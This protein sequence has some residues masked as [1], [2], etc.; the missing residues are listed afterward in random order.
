MTSPTISG[1]Q[2][3]NIARAQQLPPEMEPSP[4]HGRDCGVRHRD[5][6]TH[7]EKY[8]PGKLAADHE[9]LSQ[10]NTAEKHE[11]NLGASQNDHREHHAQPGVPRRDRQ[12][13]VLV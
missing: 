13:V 10:E 8:A 2:D 12:V 1:H 7:R 11:T 9:H 5:R 6:G 4:R 3:Q